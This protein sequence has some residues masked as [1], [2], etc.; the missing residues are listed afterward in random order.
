MM[1]FRKNF[2]IFA[3]V[4]D[5]VFSYVL[6]SDSAQKL[7]HPLLPLLLH[8]RKL[9]NCSCITSR[10]TSPITCI[11]YIYYIFNYLSYYIFSAG[12]N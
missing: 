10:I 1:F 2:P 5:N 7:L 11:Y 6:S 4:I 3:N 9:E 12:S 8:F